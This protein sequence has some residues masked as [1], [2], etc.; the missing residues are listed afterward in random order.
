LAISQS[1][2]PKPKPRNPLFRMITHTDDRLRLFPDTTRIAGDA[3][4]VGGQDLSSLAETYATPL[5]VLDR[6]TLD[7][8]AARYKSALKTHY[9]GSALITYAGKAFLCNAIAQWADQQKLWVDCTGEGEI[10]VAVAAGLRPQ[11]IVAHGVNKSA[12]DLALAIRHAG[13]IVVDNLDELALLTRLLK[14]RGSPDQS[15]EARPDVWLRL[16]PGLEVE[17]HHPHTRTGQIDSKFGMTPDEIEVAAQASSAAGLILNGLHFHLGSNFRAT[18]S[19]AAAID[20]ALAIVKV[21][22]LGDNWHFCPGG[23]WSVAYHEDELPQPE[24]DEYIRV[25][26]HEVTKRCRASGLT[27]PILHV[28]PGRSLVARAGVAIYR[29]GGVKRRGR[30][31]WLLTDGGMADNPRHALYGARYTCLPAAGLGRSWTEL[32]SVAGPCCESGDVVIEDLPMP[33]MEVGELIA[34]PVSGAYQLSMSSNY[35]GARRPAVVWLDRD[36]ARL[37]V[38]RETADDISRRDLSLT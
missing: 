20:I 28:E 37:I 33:R 17:T 32:V 26:G 21:M 24:V 30:R 5:Y 22:R 38:R 6:A 3:L 9:P 10:G 15:G 19:L 34:I 1:P 36:R 2:N 13:T 31:T 16:Q 8:A 25:I 35:N 11:S 29:V 12:A 27:L 18:A 14:F 7:A 4:S 23:G